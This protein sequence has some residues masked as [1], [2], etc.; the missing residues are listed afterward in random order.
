MRERPENIGT[1]SVEIHGILKVKSQRVL[2]GR[3]GTLK[4]IKAIFSSLPRGFTEADK[5]RGFR[6]PLNSEE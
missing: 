2:S 3:E 5:I 1:A 4:G 6:L